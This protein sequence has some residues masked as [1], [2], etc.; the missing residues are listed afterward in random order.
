M[1]DELDSQPDWAVMATF[2][3]EYPTCS[4]SQASDELWRRVYQHARITFN[5]KIFRR[6][7]HGIFMT[8]ATNGTAK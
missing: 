4:A 5:S 3:T 2:E 1:T 7:I 6:I 8:N